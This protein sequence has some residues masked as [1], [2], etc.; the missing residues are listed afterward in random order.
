MKSTKI[1]IALTINLILFTAIVRCRYLLLPSTAKK[2]PSVAALATIPATK[3]AENVEVAAGFVNTSTPQ[4]PLV[5][6]EL[7]NMI[8]LIRPCLNIGY[9]MHILY[10]DPNI[11]QGINVG[12]H[13]TV[14]E[15]DRQAVPSV[16]CGT[17]MN[18]SLTK[19]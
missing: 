8:L 14:S 13:S 18:V 3:T 16:D 9:K 6:K 1:I 12:G 10:A 11:D 2:Q 15:T 4:A 17:P 7:L 5:E 19:P